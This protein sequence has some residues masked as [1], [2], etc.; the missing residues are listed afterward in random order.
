MSDELKSTQDYI[1]AI[2]KKLATGDATEHTHRSTLET[3]VESS[4]AGV[5][6]TNEP[7]HI[8][9]I[10]NK[11]FSY[12]M[13]CGNIFPVRVFKTGESTKKCRYPQSVYVK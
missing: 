4:A 9:C 5:S 7:K 12:F 10:T 1:H 13:I 2:E 11:L 8:E 3:L 6:A